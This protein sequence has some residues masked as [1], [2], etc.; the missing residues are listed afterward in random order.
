MSQFLAPHWPGDPEQS[1]KSWKNIWDNVILLL[2]L[3][4]EAIVAEGSN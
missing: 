3:A 2:L 1:P 4:S